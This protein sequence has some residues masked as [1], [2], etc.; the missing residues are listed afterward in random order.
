ME[1][2]ESE[3]LNFISNTT[4]SIRRSLQ[5]LTFS[6]DWMS[7]R[8][9]LDDPDTARRTSTA[10]RGIFRLQRTAVYLDMLQQLAGGTFTLNRRSVDN[11]SLLAHLCEEA[12]GM[13]AYAGIRLVTDLPA[14]TVRGCMDEQLVSL[15]V[16]ELICNAASGAADG[17]VYLSVR[18]PQPRQ[19]VFTVRNR[20]DAALPEDLFARVC[21]A[22][23]E[24]HGSVGLG[25]QVV[26]LGAQ[27]HGGRLVLSED[28]SRSVTAMLSI[29]LSEQPDPPTL[30]TS[31]SPLKDLSLCH[32]VFS[33]VLPVEVF[34]LRDLQ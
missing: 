32:L 28:A 10:M 4:G 25:L 13:L 2:C 17:A 26:S 21:S 34:D 5:D 33:S 9:D 29:Q 8:L 31:L 27:C 16:L 3:L 15:L 7:D 1:L 22:P 11:R 20:A 12:G 14:R 19:L 24:F 30:K 23:E 6:L 18:A